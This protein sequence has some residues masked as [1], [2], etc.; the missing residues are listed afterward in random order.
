[1]NFFI[2]LFWGTLQYFPAYS[3]FL[4]ALRTQRQGR[5]GALAYL[6][7]STALTCLLG[8][9]TEQ[10]VLGHLPRL[11]SPSTLTEMVADMGVSFLIYMA[12][13][14]PIFFYC[15]TEQWWS[16]W[17][18]DVVLGAVA[19]LLV[20]I[21]QS[22]PMAFDAFHIPVHLFTLAVVGAVFLP[23][24][25]RL[26]D[27]RFGSLALLGVMACTMFMQAFIAAVDYQAF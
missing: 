24:L 8:A 21:A 11:H 23:L 17:R 6:S 19:G 1:V 10:Y 14:V 7:V 13:G 20:A 16:N 26:R 2:T 3:G 18:T 25:R 9:V 12:V 5:A 27:V 22:L 15:S 4:L